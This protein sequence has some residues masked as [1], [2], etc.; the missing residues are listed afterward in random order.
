MFLWVKEMI[1]GSEPVEFESAYG[2]NKSIECLRAATSRWGVFA[3]AQQAAVGK[4][5][6]SRVSLQRVIPMVGNSFKPF[7]VGRFVQSNGKVRLVGRF[8]LHWF[9]KLFIAVWLGGVGFF[10]IF[11]TIAAIHSPRNAPLPLTALAMLIFAIGL[12]RL[13]G[14]FSRNDAAWLSDI[15]RSALSARAINEIASLDARITALRS[16]SQR[17]GFTT[18][19]SFVIALWGLMGCFAAISGI[20]SAHSDTSGFIVSHFSNMTLRWTAGVSGV[21]LLA[22]AYGVYRRRLL[23]WRMGF[24]LITYSWCDLAWAMLMRNDFK[25][26][27]WVAALFCTVSFLIMLYWAYW[28]KA[29]RVHFHA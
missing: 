15:I 6:E 18:I 23:A 24:I 13:G 7:F 8:T 19:V 14:W 28:W 29:Q 11:G 26:P 27:H 25:I 12:F 1:V 20:Q 17:S 4:V 10:V 16:P 9:V 3:L 21:V 5:T 2:L 22:L